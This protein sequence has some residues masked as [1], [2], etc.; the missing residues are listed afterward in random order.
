MPIQICSKMV[1][2]PNG[3][4][5]KQNGHSRCCHSV[6]PSVG[7]PLQPQLRPRYLSLL[8]TAAGI[9]ARSGT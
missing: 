6:A 2:H 3:N 4:A 8:A 5:K 1:T 7:K 9:L